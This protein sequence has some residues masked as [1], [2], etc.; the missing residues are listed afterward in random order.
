MATVIKAF[1]GLNTVNTV[2]KSLANLSLNKSISSSHFIPQKILSVHR[3]AFLHTTSK[4]YDLM[5]FFDDPKNWPKDTVKV[6]RS[7]S[8]DELR[9]KSN[10]DLHK[11]WYVLLKERNMLLTMEHAC[12]DEYVIFPNPERYDKVEE[13]M[14]NLENVVRERNEA[15]YFLETGES[16]ERPSVYVN[17]ILGLKQCYKLCQHIIPKYC[18]LSWKEKHRFGFNGYA[19][20]KFLRLYREKLWNIKRKNRNRESNAAITL[21]KKFPDLDIEALKHK[22]PS[23]DINKVLRHNKLKG[24]RRKSYIV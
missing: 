14:K 22:Y 5:E 1:K 4:K 11:L 10:E 24:V 6:G 21:L 12:N 9:I 15:F 17:N 19:V 7:W 23:I 13:S 8:E 16:G 3:C 2:I 20:R 18:N